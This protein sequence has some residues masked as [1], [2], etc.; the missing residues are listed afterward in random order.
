VTAVAAPNTELLLSVRDLDVRYGPAAA[1]ANVSLELREG[2]TLTV[3]G[4]NGAGKST[5][6]RACSG[7]VPVAGGSIAFGS[8]DITGWGAHRVREAGLVYLPEGR[9]VFPNL[10][11]LENLRIAVMLVG[12]GSRNRLAAI[13]KVISIFPVLG[14]RRGQRAGSLSGGEQQM[15][16]LARALATDPKLVII[17]EPSL[18]LSPLLVDRVFETLQTVKNSGVTMILIEQF[19]NKALGISDQCVILRRGTVAWSGAASGAAAEVIEQYLGASGEE[20]D[21]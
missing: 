3:L 15:L 6:A 14:Q 4:S 7:L 11:V 17:D 16:A 5:F 8:V 20:G 9:G 12:G 1:L 10:S 19:V 2:V 21:S 13:D 18:G